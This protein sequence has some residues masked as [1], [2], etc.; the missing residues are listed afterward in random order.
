MQARRAGF[1]AARGSLIANVDADT[2]L[3][4]GWLGRAA[5]LFSRDRR[6]VAV[7]GPYVYYDVPWH[8]RALVR[9]FYYSAFVTYGLSRYVLR[10]GSMIQGGNFVVRRDALER[11]G[12]FSDAFSFY[13]EDTDLACR[14]SA[15]GGVKFTARLRAYSSGRRLLKE[16]VIKVFFDYSVNFFWTTFFHKPY[17]QSW[18][19]HRPRPR[20]PPVAGDPRPT[21][22]VED[23]R[24]DQESSR[25]A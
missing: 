2:I 25:P 5:A 13:G 18:A 10:V 14:L 19:D 3:P 9:V 7:S 23:G 6:L 11:I 4:E 15:V 8:T 16:G 20:T 1:L 17:T 21:F 24:P 22:A 12:G